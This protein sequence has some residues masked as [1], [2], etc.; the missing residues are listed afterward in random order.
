MPYYPNTKKKKIKY[1]SPSGYINITKWIPPFKKVEDGYGYIGIVAEDYKTGELQCHICG[2]WYE[3]LCTHIYAKH[4]IDSEEYKEQFGLL[5]STALKSMRIRK[6]HSKWMIEER[7]VNPKRRFKFKKGNKCCANRKGKPKAIES[8]NRYGVCELQVRDKIIQLKNKL[9]RTPALTE[10]IDEYGGGFAGIIHNRYS[11]YLPLVKELGWK[12]V[13][14]NKNP[15]YSKAYF[16]S[17]GIKAVSKGKKLIGKKILNQSE[18]RNIY[19]YFPSQQAWKN[20]VNRA[21][22]KK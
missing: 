13:T 3:L 19:N 22:V 21:L 8:Q 12:P 7:K 6:Q 4:H 2:K 15:K 18:V 5:T 11:G 1:D 17:K 14:S 20:A 16:V 9:G 10:V